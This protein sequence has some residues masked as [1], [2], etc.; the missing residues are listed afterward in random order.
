MKSCISP[1]GRSK[2]V[3]VLTLYTASTRLTPA[4]ALLPFLP[5]RR[6]PGYPMLSE[7]DQRQRTSDQAN[8][9]GEALTLSSPLPANRGGGSARND[10]FASAL[11][12]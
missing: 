2:L 3:S 11:G 12:R 10:P 7:S 9:A 4:H 5:T 6:P 8:S 1:P